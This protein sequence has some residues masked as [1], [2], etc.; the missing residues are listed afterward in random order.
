VPQICA[1]ERGDQGGSLACRELTRFPSALLFRPQSAKNRW[2]KTTEK[3]FFFLNFSGQKFLT[4]TFPNKF[5][6]G[7]F[8]LPLLRNAQKRHKK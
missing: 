8:E 6:Y 2:E 7:L 4:W 1:I 3:G 5:F